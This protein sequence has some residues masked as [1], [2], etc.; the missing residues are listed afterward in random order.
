MLAPLAEVE[1]AGPFQELCL[2]SLR[3][4]PALAATLREETGI[5][6]E[7]LTSGILR[8]ALDDAEERRLRELGGLLRRACR[9]TGSSPTSFALSSPG[10]RRMSGVA[11]TRR[12]STR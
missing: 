12:R 7:Y 6:I 10:C 4:F 5:D 1:D 9:C 3:M 11:S 8:V 2:E